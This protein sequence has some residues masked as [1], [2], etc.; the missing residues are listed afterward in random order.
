MRLRLLALAGA[1]L[2][3]TWQWTEPTVLPVGEGPTGVV[4]IIYA[5]T[6]PSQ[7]IASEPSGGALS[8]GTRQAVGPPLVIQSREDL[9]RQ[10]EAAVEHALPEHGCDRK[11][12]GPDWVKVSSTKKR[13]RVVQEMFR[14]RACGVHYTWTEKGQ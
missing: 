2:A 10:I 8:I 6:N 3:L 1:V 7:W 11:P 5:E 4:R 9:N 12:G 13:G 14:C